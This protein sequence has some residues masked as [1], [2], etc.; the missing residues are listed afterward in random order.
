LKRLFTLNN[1]HELFLKE[2]KGKANAAYRSSHA[3][4][5]QLQETNQIG[6]KIA[7]K[8]RAN[9]STEKNKLTSK[10]LKL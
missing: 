3:F 4:F 7:N 2:K 5:Q 9:D 8:K 6:S 10:K 1:Q